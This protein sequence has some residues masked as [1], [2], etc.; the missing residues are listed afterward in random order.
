MSTTVSYYR[1]SRTQWG[2]IQQILGTSYGQSLNFD[3]TSDFILDSP[4]PNDSEYI[5]ASIDSISAAEE[6]WLNNLC[7]EDFDMD[8]DSI[9]L[10]IQ[11]FTISMQPAYGN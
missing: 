3:L 2:Y 7:G 6:S 8:F 5:Y 10:Q 9:D 4:D 11:Y 1:L